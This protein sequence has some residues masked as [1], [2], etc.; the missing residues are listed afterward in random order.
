MKNYEV[1]FGANNWFNEHFFWSKWIYYNQSRQHKKYIMMV[2]NIVIN[3]SIICLIRGHCNNMSAINETIISIHHN[4]INN[5][6]AKINMMH[7]SQ[8]KISNYFH[9]I[10]AQEIIS[11]LLQTNII[12][13]QVRA[14]A[15]N[16]Y[17]QLILAHILSHHSRYQMLPHLLQNIWIHILAGHSSIIRRIV[18]ETIYMQEHM[19]IQIIWQIIWPQ[20]E[21]H[22]QGF[23]VVTSIKMK[24]WQ[25]DNWTIVPQKILYINNNNWEDGTLNLDQKICVSTK[26]DVPLH[27]D[28]IYHEII[29]EK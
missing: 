20:L 13:F 19:I 27:I 21:Q 15:G 17:M 23:Q 1:K 16:N 24:L 10:W 3:I 6:L 5:I 11:D 8:N 14:N 26:K 9:N 22:I 2:I 18:L 7:Q 25:A 29:Y 12:S 4:L 28:K